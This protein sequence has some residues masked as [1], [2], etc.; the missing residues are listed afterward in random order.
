[1]VRDMDPE[2]MITLNKCKQQGK[3]K[4]HHRMPNALDMQEH[5]AMEKLYKPDVWAQGS[6]GLRLMS[7]YNCTDM[8]QTII[9]Q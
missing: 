9:T 6:S 1:M 7:S 2:F 4:F 3:P 8:L 5:D